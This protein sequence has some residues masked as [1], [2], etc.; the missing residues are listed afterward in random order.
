MNSP[1]SSSFQLLH[2]ITLI[3]RLHDICSNHL[4]RVKEL[5][6]LFSDKVAVKIDSDVLKTITDFLIYH[7]NY[8][9]YNEILY[10]TNKNDFTLHNNFL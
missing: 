1:P 10:Y 5:E 7:L 3:K 2:R 6:T 4:S 9:N 8:Y